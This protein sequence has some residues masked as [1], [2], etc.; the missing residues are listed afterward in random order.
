MNIIV[1]KLIRFIIILNIIFIAEV[2]MASNSSSKETKDYIATS[3]YY[4]NLISSNDMAELNMFLSLLPKGGELHHHFSGA[5]YAENYLDFISKAGFYID[6]NSYQVQKNKP[7]KTCLS[8]TALQDNYDLYTTILRHWSYGKFFYDHDYT[9]ED[10][11]KHFFNVFGYLAPI[12]A[13]DVKSSLTLLKLRAKSENI[14]YIE[15]I[16]FPAPTSFNP[17]LDKINQLTSN[18]DDTTINS[19]LRQAVDVLD[20]DSII[21]NEIAQNLRE[22]VSNSQDIDDDDFSMRFQPYVLRFNKPSLIFSGLYSAFLMVKNNTKFVGVNIV[23]N[24]AHPI[25]LRDYK[26]HMKMF[27]FLKQKFPNVKLSLHAGELTLG[28]VTPEELSYHINDAV[29]VAEANRIGHGVDIMH[30]SNPYQLI[31]TLLNKNILVEINLTSNETLLG[32]QGN[33]HPVR[34]YMRYGVPIAISTDDPGV[35]R[36][37]LTD[38]YLKFVTCYKPSYDKLKEIVSNS[39]KYSFLTEDEKIK[40]INLLNEKFIFFEDTIASFVKKHSHVKK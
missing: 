19:V 25:A 35:S 9:Q 7:N 13:V 40:Q 6:K 21:Q 20:K 29:N 2:T 15:T 10:G 17:A 28:Q 4:H 1:K 8:V 12:E 33:D 24:E 3:K 23:G 36:N 27:R 39:I 14:Q 16:L 31:N 37:N 38:E 22:I 5:I 30:E 32:V 26:L 11:L 34:L 18:T